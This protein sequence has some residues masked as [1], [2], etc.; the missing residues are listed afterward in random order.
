[1]F[2]PSIRLSSRWQWSSETYRVNTILCL[3]RLAF[4]SI[5]W[6]FSYEVSLPYRFFRFPWRF[7]YFQFCW[8]QSGRWE[9]LHRDGPPGI[10]RVSTFLHWYQIASHPLVPF[11]SALWFI[12]WTRY[13][14]VLFVFH[15][16]VPYLF[17]SGWGKSLCY[18]NIKITSSLRDCR[19]QLSRLLL[20][21]L[22]PYSAKFLSKG[23]RKSNGQSYCNSGLRS[24]PLSSESSRWSKE[25]DAARAVL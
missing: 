16:R 18:S 15:G 6:S 24:L 12:R 20:R 9:H 17:L 5:L 3:G 14:F 4:M 22:D 8:L 23:C 21:G 25:I 2:R 10:Y 1:M 11:I 13:S 19:G 7:G